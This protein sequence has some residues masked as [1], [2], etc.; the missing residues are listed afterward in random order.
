MGAPEPAVGTGGTLIGNGSLFDA[1][2]TALFGPVDSMGGYLVPLFLCVT[3]AV[4]GSFAGASA[5]RIAREDSVVTG[6]SRCDSCGRVLRPAELVPILSFFV[7]GG[8]CRTCS[9]PID[10]LQPLAEVAGAGIGG[11]AWLFMPNLVSAVLAAVLGWQLL[12]LGLSDWRSFHLPPVGIALLAGSAL[13]LP[14]VAAFQGGAVFPLLLQQLAGGG[15]GFV[16]LAAPALAFRALSK[17]EG[18][19]SADPPLMAAIG[20]WT[21]MLGVCLIVLLAAGLGFPSR[22]P[23]GC[24]AARP[25]SFG[26]PWAMTT[27][28]RVPTKRCR[29]VLS[30]LSGQLSSLSPDFRC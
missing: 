16:L 9:G 25:I 18:M 23:P 30:C 19:G 5:L 28:R 6:R 11:A 29:W 12:V 27:L 10:R 15:L 7:L 13:V 26:S 4:V 20:L 3:G 8:R 22:S 14:A 17:R 24:P 1:G 21:G 2:L